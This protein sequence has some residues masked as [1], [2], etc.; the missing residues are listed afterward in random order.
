[1]KRLFGLCGVGALSLL[2][3]APL[4]A[5]ATK[6]TGEVI[7]VQCYT[8]DKTSRG[9][10][11]E[12]CALSCAKK[13]GKMGVLTEDGTVYVLTGTYAA[14][15]NKKLLPY[16]A[17]TVTVNGDVTETDGQKTIAATKIETAAATK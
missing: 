4:A 17:K 8:K 16:V 13:G 9:A 2:M 10:D 1:M 11:H 12:D 14:E 7:D 6:I 3:A 5:E 15:N